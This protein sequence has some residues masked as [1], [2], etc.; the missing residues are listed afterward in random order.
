METG[1]GPLSQLKKVGSRASTA[2]GEWVSREQLSELTGAELVFFPFLV[3]ST[4][5]GS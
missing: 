1:A 5:P 2:P 4:A 3:P